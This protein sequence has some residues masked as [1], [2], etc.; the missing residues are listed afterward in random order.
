M[1]KPPCNSYGDVN[2][3]RDITQ[4]DVD[5][6]IAYV[7]S[8]WNAVSSSTPLTESEFKKRADV[9]GDGSVDMGD[10]ILIFNY[11]RYP[12]EFSFPVCVNPPN[13]YGWLVMIVI[14]VLLLY[15]L[16]KGGK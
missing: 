9:G 1:T 2:G 11:M 8:G 4:T 12:T 14:A 3:D 6:I 15:L 16:T 10:A 13:E 5:L 7:T